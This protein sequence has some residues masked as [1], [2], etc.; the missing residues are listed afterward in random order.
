MGGWLSFH[1]WGQR[2]PLLQRV[3]WSTELRKQWCK[4]VA[5]QTG[6]SMCKG[7]GVVAYSEGTT[8]RCEQG[9]ERNQCSLTGI[10]SLDGACLGLELKVPFDHRS[11]TARCMSKK[12]LGSVGWGCRACTRNWPANVRQQELGLWHWQPWLVSSSAA[13]YLGLPACSSLS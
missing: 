11:E 6:N 7:P 12:T 3:L 1:T 2:R 10:G 4:S 9:E 8:R 13:S 5:F